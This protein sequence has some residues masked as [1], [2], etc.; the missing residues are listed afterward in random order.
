[1]LVSFFF[2]SVALKVDVVELGASC[3]QAWA[4]VPAQLSSGLASIAW[5]A[6]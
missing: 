1:M 6:C 5:L 2:L 4:C 3:L